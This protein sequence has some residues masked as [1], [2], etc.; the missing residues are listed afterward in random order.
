MKKKDNLYLI[1]DTKTKRDNN[2][3]KYEINKIYNF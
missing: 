2:R 3:K 1:S